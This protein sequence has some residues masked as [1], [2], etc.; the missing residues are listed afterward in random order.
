MNLTILN[1]LIDWYEE[2]K[3]FEPRFL[4]IDDEMAAIN[5]KLSLV[6]VLS[7][8]IKVKFTEF[9]RLISNK[10]FFNNSKNVDSYNYKP[11]Q[12]T[13]YSFYGINVEF[14]NQITTCPL[15]INNSILSFSVRNVKHG[16]ILCSSNNEIKPFHYR[17]LDPDENKLLSINGNQDPVYGTN[18]VIYSRSMFMVSDQLDL[19]INE[20]GYIKTNF[21]KEIH[22]LTR[23]FLKDHWEEGKPVIKK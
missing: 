9:K 17:V 16:E 19:M 3:E 4:N 13:T 15:Y 20:L 6:N 14:G 7:N 18:N 22:K 23:E 12:N 2:V 11:T 8:D 21:E 5:S 1:E 10:Y